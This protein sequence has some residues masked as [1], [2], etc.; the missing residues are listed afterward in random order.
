MN[1]GRN[2]DGY[3]IY[4]VHDLN[5]DKIYDIIVGYMELTRIMHKLLLTIV[6]PRRDSNQSS[7]NNT[8][9]NNQA[10]LYG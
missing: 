8:S 6:I 7:D 5:Y 9:G 3:C 2:Q 10:K 4:Y 1:H